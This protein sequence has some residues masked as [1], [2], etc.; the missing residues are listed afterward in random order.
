VVGSSRCLYEAKSEAPLDEDA[1]C[2]SDNKW[3]ADEVPDCAVISPPRDDSTTNEINILTTV[4]TTIKE[5]NSR[6]N[7]FWLV[8]VAIGVG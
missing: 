7:F 3:R 1:R 2:G 6:N 5:N 4:Q 8:I